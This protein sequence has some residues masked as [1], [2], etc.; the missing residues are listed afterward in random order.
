MV[1]RACRFNFYLVVAAFCLAAGCVGPDHTRKRQVT[2]LGVY[3]ETS[4]RTASHSQSISVFRNNPIQLTVEAKPFVTEAF[5]SQANVITVMDGFAISI[6]FEHRGLLLLEQ[7]SA[8]NRGRKFAVHADWGK[9]LAESRWLAAPLIQSRIANGVLTFTP[10][11]T[12]EEADEIVL[13]LNNVAKK[14][15][16][17]SE[18]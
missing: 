2:T 18:W 7:Y 5:V 15:Q 12:R 17:K 9:K 16:E 8:G 6:Q 10:D 11:C 13:G 14:V 4:T 3:L 1:A